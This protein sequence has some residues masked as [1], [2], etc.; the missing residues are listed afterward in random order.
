M[1]RSMPRSHV[2]FH[3]YRSKVSDHNVRKKYLSR[4]RRQE[5]GVTSNRVDAGVIAAILPAAFPNETLSSLSFRSRVTPV[6][7]R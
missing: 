2:L 7:S 4:N 6:L 1:P 3:D 5:M